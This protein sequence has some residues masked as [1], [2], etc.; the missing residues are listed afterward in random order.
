MRLVHVELF[1]IE[2]PLSAECCRR[3]ALGVR[4]SVYGHGHSDGNQG[5]PRTNHKNAMAAWLT[6]DPSWGSIV[7]S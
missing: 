2:L 3:C 4:A 7:C 1:V 5:R 6:I